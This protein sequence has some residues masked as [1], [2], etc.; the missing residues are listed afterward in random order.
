M[1]GNGK[2]VARD[3]EDSTFLRRPHLTPAFF[4]RLFIMFSSF[5]NFENALAFNFF[6]EAL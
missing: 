2:E 4:A 6:L 1:E 5:Q 3:S